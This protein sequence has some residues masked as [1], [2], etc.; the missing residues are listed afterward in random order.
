MDHLKTLNIRLKMDLED[1]RQMTIYD[2]YKEIFDKSHI[3][4]VEISKAA[5]RWLTSSDPKNQDVYLSVYFTELEVRMTIYEE[6]IETVIPL[7]F[8]QR[9]RHM[10]NFGVYKSK[11]T[12]TTK[13]L[14][15]TINCNGQEKTMVVNEDDYYLMTLGDILD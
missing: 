7:N 11:L 12:Q 2:F 5:R 14:K 1:L 3:G 4:S 10:C 13:S 15:I 9:M 6:T 8:F